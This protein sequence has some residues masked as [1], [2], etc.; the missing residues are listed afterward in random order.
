MTQSRIRCGIA[1]FVAAGV[2][3][4]WNPEKAEDKN[5]WAPLQFLV[6]AWTG[7]GGGKPGEAVSGETTFAF[8]LGKSILVRRN[9][10]EYAPKAGEKASIVHEDL[11]IVYPQGEGKFRA[12]YFD[13][14]GHTIQYAISFPAKQPSAVFE[15][16]PAGPGP[17]FKLVYELAADGALTTEFLMAPPGGEFMSYVKGTLSHQRRGKH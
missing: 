7:S 13:N 14:E 12:I 1:A 6:G 15:S 2:F 3:F 8:D 4:A 16:E 10:A 5:P 17:R 9:R 11:L